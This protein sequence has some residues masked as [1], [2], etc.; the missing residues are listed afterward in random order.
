[1]GKEFLKF[2]H[3]EIERLKFHSSKS[4]VAQKVVQSILLA[5]KIIKKLQG[6]VPL[7]QKLMGMW[8]IL[9]MSRSCLFLVKDEKVSG[10]HNEIWGQIKKN[11][12]MRKVW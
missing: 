6:C 8:K 9:M 12:K 3:I 11:F 4:T 2:V 1:M 10:K 7:S 5:R